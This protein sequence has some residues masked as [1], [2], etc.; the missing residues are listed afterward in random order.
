MVTHTHTQA[1]S[2]VKTD[3][4]GLICTGVICIH[5]LTLTESVH[6]IKDTADFFF[7]L[8]YKNIMQ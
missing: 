7:F 8:I 3:T 4:K 1:L 6:V 2:L 5:V